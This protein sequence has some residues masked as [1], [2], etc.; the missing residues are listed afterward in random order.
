[1]EVKML[2][3]IKN[4]KYKWLLKYQRMFRFILYTIAY[5]KK[6]EIYE[7]EILILGSSKRRNPASRKLKWFFPRLQ[8]AIAK[9]YI[10]DDFAIDHKKLLQ[11]SS[12]I[13]I[14]SLE[15]AP[16]VMV[17][18]FELNLKNAANSTIPRTSVIY[19]ECPKEVAAELP[20]LT[21]AYMLAPTGDFRD[22]Y[23]CQFLYIITYGTQ[24]R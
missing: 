5:F 21:E 18:L 24:E 22:K 13:R 23:D 7:D 19:I 2:A 6:V 14:P 10:K 4:L 16:H 17:A 15:L 1:M 12:K 8:R 11:H 20:R 9:V 3:K